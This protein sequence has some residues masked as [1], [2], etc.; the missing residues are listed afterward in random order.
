MHDHSESVVIKYA[1]TSTILGI[2]KYGS[3]IANQVWLMGTLLIQG[4]FDMY[5]FEIIITILCY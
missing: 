1:W 3:C 2:Y 5:I 4:F